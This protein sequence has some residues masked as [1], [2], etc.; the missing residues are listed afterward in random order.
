MKN[1]K[2][3]SLILTGAILTGVAGIASAADFNVAPLSV[4]SDKQVVQGAVNEE[5]VLVLRGKWIK[6]NAHQVTAEADGK[7]VDK[8]DVT[9]SV[10]PDSYKNEFGFTGKL[11]GDDIVSVDAKTGEITAKN[12]GIVRVWCTSNS[13]PDD[14]SSVVVVVPGDVNRDGVVDLEDVM[15]VI[16]YANGDE[17]EVMT[18]TSENEAMYQFE[19]AN[20]ATDDVIDLED[21]MAIMDIANGDSTI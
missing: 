15:S 11:T 8:K 6:E 17:S 3:L 2:M 20:L 19:L 14:K 12:S 10:D 7:K 1:K 13:N 5:K 4:A 16:D 9:W 18:L 21:A